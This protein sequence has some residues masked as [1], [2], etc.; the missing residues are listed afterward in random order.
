MEGILNTRKIGHEFYYKPVH[1]IFR[2]AKVNNV[3]TPCRAK[4]KRML[5]RFTV[6]QTISNP[7]RF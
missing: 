3:D 7:L 1:G 4:E 2:L 5:P 6:A